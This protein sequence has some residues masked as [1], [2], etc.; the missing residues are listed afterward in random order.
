MRPTGSSGFLAG[1]SG[2]DVM[3]WGD[4][5]GFGNDSDLFSD[6]AQ[7]VAAMGM[8]LIDVVHVIS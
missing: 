4:F 2:S 8:L 6:V 1:S 7:P 3:A 5:A